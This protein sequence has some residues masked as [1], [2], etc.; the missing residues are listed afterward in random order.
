[1]VEPLEKFPYVEGAIFVKGLSASWSVC[2][3]LIRV[4]RFSSSIWM[5]G[6]PL[7]LKLYANLWWWH[8]SLWVMSR[9]MSTF[10][11]HARCLVA[12]ASFEFDHR[13]KSHFLAPSHTIGGLFPI[14]LERGFLKDQVEVFRLFAFTLY[15]DD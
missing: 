14:A 15:G 10:A 8:G 11:N 4:R 12:S 5:P 3:L 7:G 1:M 9:S 2:L 6:W 13:Q